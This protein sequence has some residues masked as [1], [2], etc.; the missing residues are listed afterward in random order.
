MFTPSFFVEMARL[1]PQVTFQILL[2]GYEVTSAQPNKKG[3]I[4]SAYKFFVALACA[5]A[6][7][8]G[9]F[10]WTTCLPI[11]A[12]ARVP[13]SPITDTL[14]D[15]AEMTIFDLTQAMIAVSD[16][17]ATEVLQKFIGR[18]ALQAV[19]NEYGL[20]STQLPASLPRYFSLAQQG[21]AATEPVAAISTAADLVRAYEFAYSRDELLAANG[22]T[23]WRMMRTEDQ[24]QNKVWGKD[25]ICYRKSGYLEIPPFYGMTL[26]GMLRSAHHCMTFAFV[27][28][29]EQPDEKTAESNLLT[30][31]SSLKAI[32][33]HLD[34]ALV[35]T[36]GNLS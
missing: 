32:L 7:S 13:A 6:I 27:Y 24:Q 19:L 4:A 31:Q 25:I 22:E 2:D 29:F 20:N 14:P 35:A 12:T 21:V 1:N 30:F 28:N 15:G 18:T 23:F 5:Q 26:A 3:H 9:R 16:N 33:H 17:T 11:D 10:K 36:E 34:N 8:Q